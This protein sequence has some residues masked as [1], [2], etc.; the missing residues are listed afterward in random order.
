M[1]SAAKKIGVAPSGCDRATGT[2]PETTPPRR[3]T[4]LLLCVACLILTPHC[5]PGA[6]VQSAP[7]FSGSS[8]KSRGVLILP[9]AVTDDFG[10]E[11]TGIVLDHE[12]REQATR[13]ACSS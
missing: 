11:R 4:W 7:Q 5:A 1:T 12:S 10:D 2:T 13:Q 3:G 8:L 6:N 9:I